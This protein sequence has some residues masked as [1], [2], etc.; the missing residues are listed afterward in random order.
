VHCQCSQ[1]SKPYSVDTA[2][3]QLLLKVNHLSDKK[4]YVNAHDQAGEEKGS[5]GHHPNYG[6]CTLQL[7]HFEK[8]QPE[9]NKY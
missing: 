9:F 2:F 8:I 7:D 3:W 5:C 1:P 4:H 6:V